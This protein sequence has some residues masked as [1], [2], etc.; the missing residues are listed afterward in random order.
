MLK[1]SLKGSA[2]RPQAARRDTPVRCVVC[3]RVVARTSRQ[4]KFCSV[5][6]R[7]RNAYAENVR[8]GVFTDVLSQDTA[9][10]TKPTQKPNGF[11]DLR[12]AKLGSS[13]RIYGPGRVVEAEL[14]TGMDWSPATSPNGV[15]CVVARLGRR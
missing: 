4:Q 14:F 15:V 3:G 7:Q 6:C 9:L 2:S 10:P 5:R 8:T 12:V 11:N 1:R 13:S